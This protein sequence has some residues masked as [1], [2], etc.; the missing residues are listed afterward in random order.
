MANDKNPT[1][2]LRTRIPATHSE[3]NHIPTGNE[4]PGNPWDALENSSDRWTRR[5]HRRGP[6]DWVYV[7][8][9]LGIA[10]AAIL[11]ML[12]LT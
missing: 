2:Q 5:P 10:A 9:L 3:R 7:L 1:R 4:V 8:V 6:A 12:W 11:L